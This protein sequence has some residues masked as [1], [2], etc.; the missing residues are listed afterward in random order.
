MQW[1][2]GVFYRLC[3]VQNILSFMNLDVDEGMLLVK[4][5]LEQPNTQT[6]L[7]FQAQESIMILPTLWVSYGLDS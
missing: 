3:P 6:F 1:G 2:G 4:W 7:C 5:Q